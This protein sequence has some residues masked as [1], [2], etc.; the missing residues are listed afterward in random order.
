MTDKKIMKENIGDNTQK[1]SLPDSVIVHWKWDDEMKYRDFLGLR[2]GGSTETE[3]DLRLKYDKNPLE[4]ESVLI[5][6]EQLSEYTPEMKKSKIKSLLLSEDW[7]WNPDQ[8]TDF[9]K[10]T[11]KFLK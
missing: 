8:K 1:S 7:R 4:N 9:D 2:H 5:Y 10:E 3:H 6:F 11:E